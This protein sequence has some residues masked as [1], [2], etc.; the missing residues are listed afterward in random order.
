MTVHAQAALIACLQQSG[1]T[2]HACKAALCALLASPHASPQQSCWTLKLPG[3]G[4]RQKLGTLMAHLSWVL[5]AG[6]ARPER[7][8]SSSADS[9]QLSSR[10]LSPI[11]DAPA[12]KNVRR[13]NL[14]LV[15]IDVMLVRS[16]GDRLAE[17]WRWSL[18]SRSVSC[19]IIAST[20][21]MKCNIARTRPTKL[22]DWDCK[23][24]A[25]TSRVR[26]SHVTL[27]GPCVAVVSGTEPDVWPPCS[28][29]NRP[30]SSLTSACH[31][32]SY[33]DTTDAWKRRESALLQS[34]APMLPNR[35][36][37]PVG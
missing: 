15:L 13:I 16:D 21:L 34:A 4:T 37:V 24:M 6:C 17:D 11:E 32:V 22:Q 12:L 26:T 27:G 18:C 3:A 31:Q 7:L 36:L 5:P 25:C 29:L 23:R 1:D 28:R 30:D 8:S 19:R 33:R 2:W 20:E 14:S 9:A 10:P 35:P